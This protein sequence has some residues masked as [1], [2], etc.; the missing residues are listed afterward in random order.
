MDSRNPFDPYSSNPLPTS[1]GNSNNS[2]SNPTQWNQPQ[3]S[4]QSHNQGSTQGHYQAPQNSQF[5]PQSQQLVPYQ[6]VGQEQP[7]YDP[8][9]LTQYQ[10]YE[11]GAVPSNNGYSSQTQP[12][13]SP[14]QYDQQQPLNAVNYSGDVPAT[15]TIMSPTSPR[16]ASELNEDRRGVGMHH[17]HQP[18]KSP[19]LVQSK[20][21]GSFNAGYNSPLDDPKFAPPPKAPHNTNT[22]YSYGLPHFAMVKHSGYVLDLES[23]GVCNMLYYIVIQKV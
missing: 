2:S 13:A 12:Y 8:Q 1:I 22:H 10:N 7:Q 15:E 6:V 5:Q 14:Y 19:S 21:S 20:M 18:T 17:S 4:T 11:V 16:S 9:I 23:L 3:T